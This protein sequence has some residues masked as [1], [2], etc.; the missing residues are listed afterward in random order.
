MDAKPDP[1]FRIFDQ[2]GAALLKIRNDFPVLLLDVSKETAR[3]RGGCCR[4]CSR[5]DR[6]RLMIFGCFWRGD[7]IDSFCFFHFIY[8]FY[9]LFF[10]KMLTA[11]G[12]LC[13]LSLILLSL[14]LLLLYNK[15][16]KKK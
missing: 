5:G 11:L 3:C 7:I 8:F 13:Y 1:I 10:S 12:S 15:K 4:R 9:L 6:R 2:P 16:K 14:L